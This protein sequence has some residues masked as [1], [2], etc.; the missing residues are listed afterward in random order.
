MLIWFLQYGA[1]AP[2]NTKNEA[3]ITVHAFSELPGGC[4]HSDDEPNG[5]KMDDPN[6]HTDNPVNFQIPDEP[7]SHS[8]PSTVH[9][10][11]AKNTVSMALSISEGLHL[12]NGS[13]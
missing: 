13:C 9:C 2:K 11:A 6:Q 3:N 5:R 8:P 4:V 1:K 7:A 10:H 12:S